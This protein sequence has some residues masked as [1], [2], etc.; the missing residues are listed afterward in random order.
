MFPK[1]F[2][3]TSNFI[4]SAKIKKLIPNFPNLNPTSTLGKFGYHT[5][6]KLFCIERGK[7]HFVPDKI[8]FNFPMYVKW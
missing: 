3:E 7:C 5:S 2:C 1:V 8:H 6:R 4:Y